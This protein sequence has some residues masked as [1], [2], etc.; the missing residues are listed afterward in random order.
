MAFQG[1]LI[2]IGTHTED[3]EHFIIEQ[4]YH[5]S[6]KPLDLGAARD[7][8]GILRRNVLDHVP[9]TISFNIRNVNNIELQEFLNIIRGNYII[10]KE[11]K[12]SLTFYNPEGDN[13][14]TQAVYMVDP[15]FNI[16]KIDLKTNTVNFKSTQIKFIGY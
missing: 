3:L 5:V 7:G 1:Y 15:D 16:D 13:Y 6:K 10:A 2:K 9:Y 4:S 14:V 12:L 11:R 8:D